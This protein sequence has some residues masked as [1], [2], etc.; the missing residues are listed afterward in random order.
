[1]VMMRYYST[2]KQILRL[3]L[4]LLTVFFFVNCETEKQEIQVSA[5]ASMTDAVTH[6]A[7]VYESRNP[8]IRISLHTAA[9][10]TI[11]GQIIRGAPVDVFI[12]AS[13]NHM[14][15]V[16]EAGYTG[17]HVPIEL[18]TNSLVLVY[19]AGIVLKDQVVADNRKRGRS[20]LLQLRWSGI[21]RIGMG[22]PDYVP[23]GRYAA[24]LL[25]SEQLY[26]QLQDKLVLAA[27]VRQALA[28]LEA[29]EVDAAFIYR[30][31]ARLV[32]QL[33]IEAEWKRIDQGLIQY[34]AAVIYRESRK[35][36]NQFNTETQG[37]EQARRESAQA[38]L[39]FLQSEASA[40]VLRTF[41]FDPAEEKMEE[42]T[43][44]RE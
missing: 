15:R 11:A 23:A 7:E 31:D 6:L 22:N 25:K 14:Q 29:G 35:D 9:S 28:W 1:M 38:F 43:G 37:R 33:E 40:S 2:S 17:G 16:F 42:K 26:S 19:S 3:V 10:G 32:P 41:G 8:D 18:C 5:A 36:G 34:P 13:E 20:K 21:E 24:Q 27:S 30:T 12:S 39:A 4:L 44:V